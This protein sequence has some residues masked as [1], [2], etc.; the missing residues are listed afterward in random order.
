MEKSIEITKAISEN[1]EEL[2]E[3]IYQ[4][5]IGMYQM[6][7]YGS[8]EIDAHFGSRHSVERLEKTKEMIRDLSGNEQYVVAKSDSVIVGLC[9]VEKESDQNSMHAMYVLPSFQGMGIAKLLWSSVKEWLSDKDTY[10]NVLDMNVPAIK[11]YQGIGF[12]FTGKV[13]VLPG[14]TLNSMLHDAKMVL[15]VK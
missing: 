12:E 8:I 5:S 11:F 13:D 3:L 6:S 9:Y 7:G 14:L 1:A 4:S 15:K 10:L 2:N